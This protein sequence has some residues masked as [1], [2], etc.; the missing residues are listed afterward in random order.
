MT[1]T[2]QQNLKENEIQFLQNRC[3]E[4]GIDLNYIDYPIN[5]KLETKIIGHRNNYQWVGKDPAMLTELIDPQYWE[6]LRRA[7]NVHQ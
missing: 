4:L 1:V 6:R 3:R 2:I 5:G 7:E